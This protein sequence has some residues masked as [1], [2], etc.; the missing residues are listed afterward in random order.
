MTLE[1]DKSSRN[2]K[3]CTN[4]RGCARNFVE[5]QVADE[6]GA[7]Q[8]YVD[9]RSERGCTCMA[10]SD[11]RKYQRGAGKLS[12]A[13]DVGGF[14]CVLNLD[15]VSPGI[16]LTAIEIGEAIDLRQLPA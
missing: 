14:A 2:N 9:E 13:S 8:F 11:N 12:I 10:E 16:G 3:P 15:D 6:S 4:Y 1:Q 5:C 7:N